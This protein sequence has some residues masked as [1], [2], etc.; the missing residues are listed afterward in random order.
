MSKYQKRHYED[1]ARIIYDTHVY[2]EEWG[3]A[4]AKITIDSVRKSMVQLFEADNKNF[5]Q[6]RFNNA[7]NGIRR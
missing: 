2:A 4:L 6:E 3:G 5:D 1:M 7:C